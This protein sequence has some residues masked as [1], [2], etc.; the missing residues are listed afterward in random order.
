M[1]KKESKRPGEVICKLA[2][3]ESADLIVI[4]SRGI[5]TLRRTFLGCV[6]DYCVRH[7][8]IP[9]LVVLPSHLH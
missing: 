4:G 9:V 5:G 7:A 2:E 8:N 6:S 1:Y 3:D